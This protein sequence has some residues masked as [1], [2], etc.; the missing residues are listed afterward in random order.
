MRD[1]YRKLIILFSVSFLISL[2]FF[3]TFT[4]TNPFAAY[5]VKTKPANKF[6]DGFENLGN[7]E[8][9]E[10]MWSVEENT[11]KAN[12]TDSTRWVHLKTINATNFELEVE[13]K[14]MSVSSTNWFGVV[15]RILNGSSYLGAFLY[16]DYSGGF[17]KLY[18]RY[19][20]CDNIVNLFT[21]NL[22]QNFTSDTWYTLQLSMVG[23]HVKFVVPQISDAIFDTDMVVSAYTG[24]GLMV[25]GNEGEFYF[26]NLTITSHSLTDGFE[27][28]KKAASFLS[29]VAMVNDLNDSNYGGI[30]GIYYTNGSW[31]APSGY[32]ETTGYEI[33]SL[34]KVYEVESNASILRTIMAA[35]NWEMSAVQYM[36]ANTNGYG[37]IR[38]TH[39]N[40]TTLHG[41]HTATV[42][43]GLAEAWK[44]S[45][46]ETYLNRIKIGMDFIVR[47]ND[48]Q[49]KIQGAGLVGTYNLIR[50][51]YDSDYLA[52][53]AGGQANFMLSVY[54]IIQNQTY[55]QCAK[56]NLDILVSSQL[57]NGT[58]WRFI[59]NNGMALPKSHS[60]QQIENY[61]HYIMYIAQGLISGYRI[62]GNS[63][64][65]EAAK[66]A[67]NYV[68]TYL[69]HGDGIIGNRRTE[70]AQFG[71][72]S[73]MLY[74]MTDNAT[75]LNY[76]NQQM[77][78]LANIQGQD[79][80]F[81]NDDLSKETWADKFTIDF[82]LSML[83]LDEIAEPHLV[84]VSSGIYNV[85]Q[86]F[87]DHRLTII[88][89]AS[90][91]T[92]YTLKATADKGKPFSLLINGIQK[93]EGYWFYDNFSNTITVT[94]MQSES[95]TEL[96]LDFDQKD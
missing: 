85:V 53:S 16:R 88:I 11:L 79:G 14:F 49:Q 19:V 77:S 32:T 23:S 58:W 1:K 63:T 51:C 48:N 36:G 57:P 61:A 70:I 60:G 34:A 86:S 5:D 18:L 76:A 13:L 45:G 2:L 7:W 90:P 94:W 39:P 93:S 24:F 28:V 64:Y 12:G 56:K 46:N 92:T 44:L 17:S 30:R 27:V 29:D 73:K 96:V 35:S 10:G 91:A 41:W 26:D 75:Y 37:G 55:L 22:S 68:V 4:Q 43:A 59:C 8:V 3:E 9:K 33:Q 69:R 67:W 71:L 78:T 21:N 54:E 40:A 52:S 74:D 66:K 95:D 82:I 50:R 89:A 62:T 42:M 25:T 80:G 83:D 20:Q 47:A 38:N 72:V 84:Y 15:V 87:A 31:F 81:T 6:F 65:L